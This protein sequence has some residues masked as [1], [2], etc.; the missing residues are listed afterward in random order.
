[1]HEN[2]TNTWKVQCS[3]ILTF[4]TLNEK[5]TKPFEKIPKNRYFC[6][7]YAHKSFHVYKIQTN[8]TTHQV[9]RS[10][11]PRGRST[12]RYSTG[13]KPGTPSGGCRGSCRWWRG[14]KLRGRTGRGWGTASCT[15]G[16]R[17]EGERTHDATPIPSVV[18]E[19]H[20]TYAT[21][22]DTHSVWNPQN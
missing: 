20:A 1:M 17:L 16:G 22:H 8:Q 21:Y 9:D 14:H 11:E 7:L 5:M 10:T 2:I 3:F 18:P 13:R 6:C 19:L 4:P 12:N 15:L